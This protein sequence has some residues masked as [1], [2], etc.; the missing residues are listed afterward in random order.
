MPEARTE[1]QQLA[2]PNTGL[3]QPGEADGVPAPAA[4]SSLGRLR[5]ALNR[6]LT[7]GIP[8]PGTHPGGHG[9]GQTDQLTAATADEADHPWHEQG[10]METPERKEHR[11]GR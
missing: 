9:D 2:A 3:G 11:A 1:L 7:E 10:G 4:R 5:L 6:V 8:L